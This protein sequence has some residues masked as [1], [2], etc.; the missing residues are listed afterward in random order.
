MSGSKSTEFIPCGVQDCEENAHRKSNGRKGWCRV[1]Y[2]TWI[3]Y[4]NT[5]GTGKPI[6]RK[7]RK[8]K[9]DD[10]HN[11][12]DTRSGG[13]R[14]W[15]SIHYSRW[16]VYGDPLINFRS[17]PAEA[18]EF[19]RDL[20]KNPPKVCVEWPYLTFPDGYGQ[21]SFEGSSRRASRVSLILYT[22]KNPSGLMSC[23]GQCHNHKCVNPL[24]LYWGT[25]GENQ[26]DRIRDGTHLRGQKH[27]KAKLTKE[28][29][30]EIWRSDLSA[31]VLAKKF[32]VSDRAIY[33]IWRRESWAWLTE[34]TP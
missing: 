34:D 27:P 31:R 7:Y 3:K 24:H 8:C 1:H 13:S 33:C 20:V 9:I 5:D 2:F 23:H 19:L 25:P 11:N 15:C 12:V 14:G 30:L 28:N 29:V 22:G 17:G 26:R 18:L 21:V 10:C 32:K 4:G 16:K 6:I